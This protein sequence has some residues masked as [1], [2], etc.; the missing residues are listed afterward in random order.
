[1]IPTVLARIPHIYV[2]QVSL[3]TV[4]Y[5]AANHGGDVGE[6]YLTEPYSSWLLR[7]ID[8]QQDSADKIKSKPRRLRPVG[9]VSRTG[10]S[11]SV[12]QLVPDNV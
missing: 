1:M 11:G 4:A 10:R 12:I 9:T 2:G 6:V 8:Q 7:Q 3:S 5:Y